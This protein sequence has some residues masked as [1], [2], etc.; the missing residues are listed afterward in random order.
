MYRYNNFNQGL[1]SG[2]NGNFTFLDNVS[3]MSFFISL[4]NLNENL[5]QNDKQDL[6]KTLEHKSKAI[7]DQIHH[8]L[9][10]QDQKIDLILEKLEAL[11]KNDN[12]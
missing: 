6:Q 7:L 8:H 12:R 3:L 4:M 10:I 9:Q 2:V 5:T 11:S 1:G